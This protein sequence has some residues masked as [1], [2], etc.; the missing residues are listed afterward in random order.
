MTE[1]PDREPSLETVE[2]GPI[3]VETSP[4]AG[5]VDEPP[6]ATVAMLL[7]LKSENQSSEAVIKPVVATIFVGTKSRWPRPR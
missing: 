1:E 7:S 5:A 3:A 6:V 4:V 2:T